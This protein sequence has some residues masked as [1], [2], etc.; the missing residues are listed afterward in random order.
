MR[1]HFALRPQIFTYADVASILA[2]IMPDNIVQ[3]FKWLLRRVQVG[4]GVCIA[5]YTC[6][7]QNNARSL[8]LVRRG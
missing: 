7:S 6:A 1:L 5:L 2:H 3:V 8:S 4:K